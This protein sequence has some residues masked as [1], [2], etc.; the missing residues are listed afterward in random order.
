MTANEKLE[1]RRANGG[2]AVAVAQVHMGSWQVAYRGVIPDEYLDALDVEGRAS[3]YSFDATGPND[4]ATWITVEDSAVV[5]FVTIGPCRDEDVMGAGEIYALYVAPARWRSGIGARLMAEGEKR[6]RERE[7]I[8]AVIWV[9]AR[10][11]RARAFYEARGW[12]TDGAAKT[13]D[14]AAETLVEVRYRSALVGPTAP[15]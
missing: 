10:N 8:D 13:I 15:R 7:F 14:F 9:L 4:L 2:D 12:R 11:P 6:L 3:R 5:G 1:M